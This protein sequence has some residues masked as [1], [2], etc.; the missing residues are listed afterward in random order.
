[1]PKTNNVNSDSMEQL[2]MKRNITLLREQEF[3]KKQIDLLWQAVISA[4]S[5]AIRGLDKHYKDLC[6]KALKEFQELQKEKP[7]L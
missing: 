1:M 3:H 4:R 6:D 5:M 2:L 7:K